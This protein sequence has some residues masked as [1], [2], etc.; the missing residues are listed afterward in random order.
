M[1]N[2]KKILIAYYSRTGNTERVAKDLAARL[3]AD[4]EKIVDK[5]DRR[6]LFGYI[7]AGRDAMKKKLTEIN[8]IEKDP[9]NYDLVIIGTPVWAWDATPAIR[10]YIAQTRGRIKNAAYF[11]TSGSTKPEKIISYLE[12]ITQKKAVASAG[13]NAAELKND[14]VYEEKINAFSEKTINI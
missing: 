5:K 2:P 10:A 9:V 12:E 1:D 7:F 6:G 13:F 3:G 11:I 4:I 14:K 8:D